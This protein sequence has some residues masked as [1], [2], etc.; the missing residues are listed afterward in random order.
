MVGGPGLAAGDEADGFA[1][2]DEG[3]GGIHSALVAAYDGEFIAF[4]L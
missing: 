1:E 4:E 2:I 3:E